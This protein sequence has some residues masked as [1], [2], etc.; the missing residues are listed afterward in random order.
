MNNTNGPFSPISLGCVH[1]E[2][3]RRLPGR[4]ARP[5]PGPRPAS[6]PAGDHWGP[7]AAALSSLRPRCARGRGRRPAQSLGRSSTVHKNI[8]AITSLSRFLPHSHLIS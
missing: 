8:L 7:E 4:L 6:S 3:S 2:R 5:D 1:C